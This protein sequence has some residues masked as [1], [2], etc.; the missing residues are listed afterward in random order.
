MDWGFGVHAPGWG[1]A[2]GMCVVGIVLLFATLHLA[3]AVGR[4]HGQ[5][6]KHMLEPRPVA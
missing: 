1:D 2:I 3:R 5:I 6:A 4:M